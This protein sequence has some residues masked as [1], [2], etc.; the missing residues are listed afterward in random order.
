M[1]TSP[2]AR[3]LVSACLLGER[4]RY[5]GAH[6]RCDDGALRRWIDEGRVIAVCPEVAGGLGVP[7]P[8]AEIT[9]AAGGS[10]VLDGDA[11]VITSEADDVT[12]AFLRGAER[13]LAVAQAHGVR[14]AVLKEG[15][16]S[17]GV[18]RTSDGS[19]SGV[20]ID[21][22]GVTAALLRRHGIAVFSEHEIALADAA[23]ADL[24]AGCG[25]AVTSVAS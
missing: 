21:D 7:R 15:S 10:G 17:C 2:I 9:G 5:N 25:A 19:F 16:P 18:R 22:S 3:V 6:K 12:P 20:K 4:V 11:R 8:A 14:V 1:A 23:L 24:S 13:A